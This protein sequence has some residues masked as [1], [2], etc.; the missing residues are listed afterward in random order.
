MLPLQITAEYAKPA[1]KKALKNNAQKL[2]EFSDLGGK[3]EPD[4]E[5]VPKLNHA[6]SRQPD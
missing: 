6:R 4:E 1:E 5:Y 3:F 2:C